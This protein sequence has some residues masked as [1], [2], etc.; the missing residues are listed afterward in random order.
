MM[1]LPL[2]ATNAVAKTITQKVVGRDYFAIC[3]ALLIFGCGID[4]L[5]ISDLDPRLQGG[6]ERHTIIL[7]E[8]ASKPEN[9]HS[10]VIVLRQIV[11]AIN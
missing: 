3:I 10:N 1:R 11:A 4:E 6:E 5:V 7:S 2:I 9:N 8:K